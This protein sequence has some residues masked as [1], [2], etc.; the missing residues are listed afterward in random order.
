MLDK[1]AILN[2]VRELIQPLLESRQTELVELTCRYEGSRI[3]LRCLVD[4]AR[5]ITL[6][7]L[8]RLNQAI[9]AL[10]DE[11]DV[12]SERYLLEVSS[13]GLDRPLRTP[14]DF[15]RMIGRRIKVATTVPI[16]SLQEIAGEL[17][18]SN[19]RIITLKLDDGNKLQIALSEII[20][21]VQEIKL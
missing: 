15:E 7:E 11:Y 16:N 21:A 12:I 17:L 19:E 14:I 1:E 10:L 8:S 13:P 6:D 2:R 9:G 3:M 20:H 5:G 18:G 4:T